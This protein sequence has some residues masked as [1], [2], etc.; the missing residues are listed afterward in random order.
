[1]ALGVELVGCSAAQLTTLLVLLLLVEDAAQ[2]FVP[3]SAKTGLMRRSR[4]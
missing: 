2:Q 1:V 3:R 4:D